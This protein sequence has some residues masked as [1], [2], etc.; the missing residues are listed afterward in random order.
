MTK[1]RAERLIPLV[2]LAPGI[3]QNNRLGGGFEGDTE[4]PEQHIP[5]TG[6][7]GRDWEVCMTMNDTWGYKSYDDN[8][9]STDVLIRKLCDIASKGGNF[10][11]NIGNWRRNQ[12]WVGWKFRITEPGTFSI[13]TEIAS[14]KDLTITAGLSEGEANAVEIKGSGEEDRFTPVDLGGVDIAEP[15]VYEL[16]IRVP[17]KSDRSPIRIRTVRLVPIK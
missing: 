17:E 12:A 13:Q 6:F 4:T 5:A 10:L 2:R 8:W 11:L 15:G 16:Q 7:D 3:I 1:E 14:A 9:K